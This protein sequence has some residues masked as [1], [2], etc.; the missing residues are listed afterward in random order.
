[1][2]LY[3][4]GEE[5][6]RYLAILVADIEGY[7]VPASLN[8]NDKIKYTLWPEVCYNENN[9]VTIIIDM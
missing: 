7:S 1:M 5:L 8:H 3:V 9:I 6:Q 2:A 4:K